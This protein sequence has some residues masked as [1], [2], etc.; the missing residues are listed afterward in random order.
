MAE[1]DELAAD[2]LARVDGGLVS[3]PEPARGLV[4]RV[5]SVFDAYLDPAAGRPAAAV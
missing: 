3:V 1:V 5:A 2:G 4:R